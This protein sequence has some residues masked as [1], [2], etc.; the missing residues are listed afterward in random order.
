MKLSKQFSK[1]IVVIALSAIAFGALLIGL[2][3][4]SIEPA[5]VVQGEE[6]AGER[7]QDWFY[8]Q[9]A[10]P[11][12]TIPPDAPLRMRRQLEQEELRLRQLR[13]SFEMEP[14]QQLVWAALG[15]APINAGQTF[16][17]P[18]APVSGRVPALALD[19]R[20]NGTTNQ[21]L[22]AGAAQGGLWRST[23]NGAQWTPLT[24]G[25]PSLAVGSIAIDPT[26]PNIIYVGTGEGNRS[27][28]TYY[29]LGVLKSTDGGATW[30]QFSGPTSNR[31]PFQPA[32]VNASMGQLVIDPTAPNTLFACTTFGSTASAA[33][34]VQQAPLGQV[35]LWKSTDGGATWRNA[36]PDGTDGQFSAQDVLIDPTNSQRVFAAVRTV[37]LYRSTGGGE[38]GTWEKLAGG[39]PTGSATSSPFRRIGLAAGPPIAPSTNATIYAAYAGSDDN[40]LGIFRSTDGGTNWNRL[41]SPQTAGQANYNLALAVDPL[42]ANIVYYGT[43][44]NAANAGGT[45]FRSL[46][47][48]QSWSDLSRGD[49][50]DGLHADTHTIL[51]SPAN[52]NILFTGNDGGVWRTA[53]ATESTVVW[54]SLNR[55]LNVTQFQSLALHPTNPNFVI[56]GTQDN[57]TNL[58]TG[59]L[60]W[61][62]IRGGDGGFTLIDQSNPQTLYHTFFNQNNS[63]GQT[64]QIGPEIS[65]NGGSTWARRGCFACSARQGNFNPA[66]R[67]AFYAPMAL[68]TGFTAAS[69]NVI[70]FGTHRL[71]R[72]DNQGVTWTGLGTSS[73]GFG[74]DLT[75]G[76]GFLTTVAAHPNRAG[77]EE[78]VW[79]GTSDGTIQ[80]TTNAGAAAGATFTNVTRAPL[81]NRFV[82]DIA[83]D[84]NN[85]QRAVAVFSGF[86]SVTPATPGHVF[87]T[88][89]RGQSWTDISG[90]LPDVPV[91]STAVNPNDANTIYIGTDLGV[92]QTTNGGAIWERMGNGMPR[93]ATF[94]VRYQAATNMLF[95]ATHGRGVFRLTTSRPV[96]TVSAASFS[97]SAIAAESIAA[98]FGTGLAT[99][100]AIA[101]TLPLPTVL[102]GTRVVVR[103]SAGVERLSPLFFVAATQVNFLIPPGTAAGTASITITADDGT[104]STGTVEVGTVAPSLFA[105]N[106]SGRDVPAGFA[107]RIKANGAQ[108]NEPILRF[109]AAQNRFVPMPIDVG[110]IGDQVFL[111]LFGTG[112]R[113]RS[114]LSGVS[115]NIGGTSLPVLYAGPQGDFVGLD[116]LNI[117]LP[118]SLAGRGEVDLTLTVDGR[119]SNTLRINLK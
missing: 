29:G 68:H 101:N 78:L 7:R 39:L 55:T 5:T 81:P 110:V 97:A 54:K 20:Y 86:N 76:D 62:L 32:F 99:Q 83:L 42:D 104:V 107:L 30:T 94:M 18:G 15:P 51:V 114:V 59:Q 102:A 37:G 71:Y 118:S 43:Q 65:L 3:P 34:G 13:A 89:N 111:V 50:S 46:N 35:G 117:L 36:N 63:G 9:R 98:A 6:E 72:S 33:D 74:A 84:P 47:G 85:S 80:F 28:D 69:G 100:T 40:L 95:A 90:N 109:D 2:K 48:G 113:F 103:D 75:K 112:I 49:G 19:P 23:D 57:G 8:F 108:L 106:A 93:V 87:L 16:S 67:V 12:K 82:T 41:T 64:P 27:S 1:F 96:S 21:T 44:A 73:D 115:V 88:A 119:T 61:D 66:D 56:G 52:R 4:P 26:N 77:G 25:Q 58:F 91:T 38:P 31:D 60:G 11:A 70:Y 10:Y 14:E 79:I 92:F 24:D 17:N 22:Y 105:A 116:Q 45:F 53:N